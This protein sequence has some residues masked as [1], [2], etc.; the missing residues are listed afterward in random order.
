VT[1]GPEGHWMLMPQ[2]SRALTP[3][4]LNCLL[5]LPHLPQLLSLVFLIVSFLP[6]PIKTDHFFSA[7]LYSSFLFT[8]FRNN[9]D[10]DAVT[11]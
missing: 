11:L 3:R 6:P 9:Y 7:S 8:M 1:L 4:H 5:Q 10:N 2:A